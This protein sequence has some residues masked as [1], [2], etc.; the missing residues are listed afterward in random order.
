MS[1]IVLLIG[2][3]G[4]STPAPTPPSPSGGGGG[5]NKILEVT[6]RLSSPPKTSYTTDDNTKY[7]FYYIV[8]LRFDD[9]PMSVNLEQ[10]DEI[11]IW[12][13]YGFRRFHRLYP[14]DSEHPNP[15]D[16]WSSIMV[17]EDSYAY[18]NEL[19][20][21][22]PL[23]DDFIGSPTRFKV[24]AITKVSTSPINSVTSSF[25]YDPVDVTGT[26]DTPQTLLLD[27]SSSS[28]ES[29]T[30]DQNDFSV[31]FPDIPEDIYRSLDITEVSI[32]EY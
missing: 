13:G 3:Y 19:R 18:G 21:R 4:C 29:L 16:Q 25:T 8:A 2:L 30:D 24:L 1:L 22:L 12:G 9:E 26:L 15:E 11:F 28:Y 20:F 7:Y 23:P 6:L 10:W 17:L 31:P 14:A 27:V 32:R 5:S